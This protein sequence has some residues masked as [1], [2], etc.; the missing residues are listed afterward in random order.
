MTVAEWL[1]RGLIRPPK[2]GMYIDFHA[3]RYVHDLTAFAG[4][5]C[6]T[7]NPLAGW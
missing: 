7:I 3:V 2:L 6:L 1:L 4:L 5:Q